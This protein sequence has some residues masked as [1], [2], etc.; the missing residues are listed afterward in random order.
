MRQI[1]PAFSSPRKPS[2]P[3]WYHTYYV[4][5]VEGDRSKALLEIENARI[6]IQD[7]L[8]ELRQMPPS[9]PRELQDLANALTYLGILLMYIGSD[10]G[11]MLWD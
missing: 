8:T 11:N 5:M 2:E 9:N 3:L 4:A 1:K 6:A 7:R 10:G